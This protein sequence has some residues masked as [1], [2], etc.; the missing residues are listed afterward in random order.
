M[1]GKR[2]AGIPAYPFPLSAIGTD[3]D[4][5][6]VRVE[7]FA[8]NTGDAAGPF[9]LGIDTSPPNPFTRTWINVPAGLEEYFQRKPQPYCILKLMTSPLVTRRLNG[10]PVR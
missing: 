2:K 9:S 1:A 8:D 3:P 7:F 10:T 5:A 6:V 4:G